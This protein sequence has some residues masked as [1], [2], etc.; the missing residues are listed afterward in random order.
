MLKVML[1]FM[2]SL[3]LVGCFG[4]TQP[5]DSDIVEMSKNQFNQ[6][7]EGLFLANGVTKHNGYKQN[8]THYVAEVSVM[9]QAQRSLEAY[10]QEMLKDSSLS[11]IEKIKRTMGLGVLKLS[12]PD[13]QQGDVIE[14]ERYYLFIKTDNG[15]R[16]QKS[17]SDEERSQLKM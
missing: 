7:F 6:E 1:S 4:I 5:T 8:D 3:L 14:F 12:L 13:F 15:W 10:S 17:L 11:P 16:L 2:L 9:G